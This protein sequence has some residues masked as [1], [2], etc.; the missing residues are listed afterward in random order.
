MLVGRSGGIMT[1]LFPVLLGGLALAGIPVLLHLIMRQKPKHLLFPAFRFLLQRHRTNQ[2]KLRLRHL[3][4]LALRI[5]LIAFLCLALTRPKIFSDRFSFGDRPVAAVLLFDTSCSMGYVSGGQSLLD[6]ARRRARELLDELR[7][8]S[9][10]AILDTAEPVGNWLPNLALAR[11]RIGELRLRPANAPL[12]SRLPEAY[13]LF[14]ELD[15]DGDEESISLPRFLYVFSDRT[16]NSWDA[17]RAAD[18]E[19]LRERLA[20]PIHPVYVDLGV[21]KPV[22]VALLGL[23]LPR[24]ALAKNERAEIQVSVR[25]TGAACETEMACKIDEETTP[26]VKPVKLEDGQNQVVVFSREGLE[27]GLHQVEIWLRSNDALVF[28]NKLYGTFEIRGARKVLIL[29][30]NTAD[31]VLLKAALDSIKGFTYDVRTV[32]EAQRLTPS[33]DLNQYQAVCLL[34]VF[35][36]DSDL[37]ERLAKYVANGGGLAVMP[38]DPDP[39]AYNSLTAQQLL[40]GTLTQIISAPAEPGATWLETNFQHPAMAEFRDWNMKGNIDFV[41]RP[42]AARRY[43]EVKPADGNVA[44]TIVPYK[45]YKDDKK[46]PA[47]LERLFDPKSKIRGRV[48]LFTTALDYSHLKD[49]KSRWNDYVVTTFYLALVGETLG[50]LVGNADPVNFNYV[51]GQT[52]TIALTAA[53]LSPTYTLQGGHLSA[54]ESIVPR[55]ENQTELTLTQAVEPD[56]YSLVREGKRI[57]AFSVNAPAEESQLDRIPAE[58]IDQALGEGALLPVGQGT[59]L[60]DALQG[61]WSQPIELFPWLM[62]LVLLALAIEN[63]LA[64]TFY[65]QEGKE[66]NG[67]GTEPYTTEENAQPDADRG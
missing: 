21:D 19:R 24:Q 27:P 55:S 67:A 33:N 1:F 58:Q 52:V 54:A 30:D 45:A 9:H 26:D 38:G 17:G 5:G 8:E 41:Q 36:P 65:R 50:Y 22:D 3:L 20:A 23:R 14:A 11:D 2:R 49:V 32:Q 42:P 16:S 48:L 35:K 59:N 44:Y 62:I 56:N 43:W 51:S 63:F 4:L 37:W 66:E 39:A 15:Q 13:R 53:D 64:N 18:L 7:A 12:T 6:E 46:R 47:L 60:R 57:A 61:H 10:V 28:N 29:A 40:P 25:A 34:N 31:A